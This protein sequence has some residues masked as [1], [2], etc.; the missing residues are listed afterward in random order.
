MDYLQIFAARFG[1]VA[2]PGP[3]LGTGLIGFGCEDVAFRRIAAAVVLYNPENCFP[4]P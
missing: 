4:H 2:D 3:D 1:E